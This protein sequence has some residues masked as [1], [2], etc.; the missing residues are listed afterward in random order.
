[1][2]YGRDVVDQDDYSD[3]KL[4]GRII[5]G[6]PVVVGSGLLLHKPRS[7]MQSQSCDHQRS[8][9]MRDD[10]ADPKQNPSEEK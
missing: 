6:S 3:H 2:L 1:M 9:D 7:I 5:P 10:F 8:D 4:K